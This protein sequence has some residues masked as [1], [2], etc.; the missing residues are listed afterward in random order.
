MRRRLMASYSQ[1]DKAYMSGEK[2]LQIFQFEN[3]VL[4]SDSPCAVW[5]LVD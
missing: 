5:E 4:G 3:F 2:I 1:M